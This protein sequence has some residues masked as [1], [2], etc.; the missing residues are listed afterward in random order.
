MAHSHGTSDSGMGVGMVLGII[1]A[2]ILVLLLAWFAFGANFT[3]GS[4]PADRGP[5]I[6]IEQPAPQ[7]SAPQQPAPQQPAP[8]QPAPKPAG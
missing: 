3:G 8:Q 7:Q 2:L 1:L 6:R 4:A 5:D